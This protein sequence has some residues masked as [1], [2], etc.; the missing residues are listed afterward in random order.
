MRGRRNGLAAGSP[1]AWAM[2]SHALAKRA[3]LPRQGVVDEA[4]FRAHISAI[5]QRLVQGGL[6]LAA[7]LNQSLSEPPPR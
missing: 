7:A 1:A 2:E 3:L 6:R 5:D 4:Y